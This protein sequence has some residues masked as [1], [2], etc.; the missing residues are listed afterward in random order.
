MFDYQ[1]FEIDIQ[2]I[3]RREMRLLVQ[4]DTRAVLKHQPMLVIYL[5]LTIMVLKFYKMRKKETILLQL[6][7]KLILRL[8]TYMLKKLY[9][10]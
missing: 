3:Y 1:L 2:L 7:I 6:K 9:K 8:Y 4:L 10:D 5:F